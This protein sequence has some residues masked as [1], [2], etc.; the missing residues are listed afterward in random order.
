MLLG[1]KMNILELARRNVPLAV[2][3]DGAKWMHLL[4][5]SGQSAV[6]NQCQWTGHVRR[7]YAIP[8]LQ[9]LPL[10]TLLEKLLRAGWISATGTVQ[11]DDVVYRCILW[12]D[13]GLMRT[14]AMAIFLEEVGP[15]DAE[16]LCLRRVIQDQAPP[17][18]RPT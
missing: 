4:I 8:V 2:Q 7:W 6:F 15:T 1:I 10:E 9:P 13:E 12:T 11:R 18:A 3:N 14:A 5:T 16:L 17:R